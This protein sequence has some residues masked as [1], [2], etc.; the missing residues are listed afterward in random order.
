[1]AKSG[2][3]LGAAYNTDLFVHETFVKKVGSIVVG[4]HRLREL[5]EFDTLAVTGKSGMAI[6][7]GIQ[8]LTNEFP[9]FVVKKQ[10]E[11]NHSGPINGRPG[12][13]VEKYIILDDFIDTGATVERIEK[14]VKSCA[15]CNREIPP[16]LVGAALYNDYSGVVEYVRHVRG[17]NKSF[18][19]YSIHR[20]SQG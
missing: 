6:A 5:V 10:G 13:Q 4:L 14:E 7:F 15:K 9:F 11:E 18:K 17:T 3:I 8:M 19:C 1:M 20:L 12:H 16:L 2:L